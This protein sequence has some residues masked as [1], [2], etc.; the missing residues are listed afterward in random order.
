MSFFDLTHF[1]DLFLAF[2]ECKGVKNKKT[3]SICFYQ[4]KK[5]KEHLHVEYI[6]LPRCFSFAHSYKCIVNV[7][8]KTNVLLL[9]SPP[10]K[11]AKKKKK[12]NR[13]VWV[14]GIV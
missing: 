12:R 2:I 10:K 1:L 8:N 14:E 11:K 3:K 9:V 13:V 5:K 6:L 7:K 4:K